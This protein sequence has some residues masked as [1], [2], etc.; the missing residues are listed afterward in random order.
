MNICI[1]FPTHGANNI[2]FWPIFLNSLLFLML[3]CIKL[4]IWY[5]VIKNRKFHKKHQKSHWRQ[6]FFFKTSDFF[7]TMGQQFSKWPSK[8]IKWEVWW[9]N[10]ENHTK[11]LIFGTF[12]RPTSHLSMQIFCKKKYW[13]SFII[14]SFMK[15]STMGQFSKNTLRSLIFF[16]IIT[17]FYPKNTLR[18]VKNLI[19]ILCIW[20]FDV[21]FKILFNC[22]L[23]S[24]SFAV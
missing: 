1:P 8:I 18:T 15:N 10:L 13:K 23:A 12:S 24:Y 9:L 21:F 7:V 2:I 19:H 17:N 16:H 3:F 4:F 6:I 22:F 14:V 20:N 11:Y 5:F